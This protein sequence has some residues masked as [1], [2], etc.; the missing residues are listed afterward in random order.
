M[1]MAKLQGLSWIRSHGA[2]THLQPGESLGFIWN[3]LPHRLCLIVYPVVQKTVCIFKKQKTKQ[4]VMG[5]VLR[6][7]VFN[8]SSEKTAQK[9]WWPCKKHLLWK[10][11]THYYCFLLFLMIC[12]ASV[13]LPR[14]CPTT[15][16]PR[17][18]RFSVVDRVWLP[19]SE[20][21]WYQ[22]EACAFVTLCRAH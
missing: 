15:R 2:K 18:W 22:S 16:K 9:D 20:M 7:R 8:S 3:F 5:G 6:P 12:F 4:D 21:F 13:L 10:I 17:Y 14:R 1:I 19:K 11:Q